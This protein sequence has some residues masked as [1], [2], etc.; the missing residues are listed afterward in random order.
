MGTESE[1]ITIARV[2]KPQGRRGEVAAEL[3]TDFP[4][5]FASRKRIFLLARDGRRTEAELESHWLHKGR[6]ILKFRG[7]DSISAA[8]ALAGSEVQISWTERVELEAGAEYIS[9]LVGSE[10][11]ETSGEAR[12]LGEI[13]DILFGAGEAPLLTL[14]H[15][16]A[17]LLIPFAEAYVKHFDRERKRLEVVLPDGLL[18]LAKANEQRGKRATKKRP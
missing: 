7:V 1:F 3:H 6:V 15:A 13:E 17:E 10:V 18:E 5:R 11:F 8:E 12:S 16:G 2:L 9:D 14:K 4:E